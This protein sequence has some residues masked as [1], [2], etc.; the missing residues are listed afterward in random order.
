[1]RDQIIKFL[2]LGLQKISIH[3]VNPLLVLESER[4]QSSWIRELL[5]SSDIKFIDCHSYKMK[6]VGNFIDKLDLK[7]QTTFNQ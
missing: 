4:V 3:H 7:N 6:D 2:N 1:M 5:Q